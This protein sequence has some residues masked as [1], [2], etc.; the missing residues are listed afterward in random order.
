[1]NA[2]M[3]KTEEIRSRL[4]AALDPVALDVIDDSEAH[5]GHGGWK[6]GGETHFNVRIRSQAFEGQSRL[7]RHRSVHAALGEDL[8][9]RIHALSLDLDTPA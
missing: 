7:Q 2:A 5:R 3:T 9:A 6:E 4:Q 8:V 1:M